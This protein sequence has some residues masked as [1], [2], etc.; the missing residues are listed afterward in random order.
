MAITCNK[1]NNFRENHRTREKSQQQE[2]GVGW[3]TRKEL[4]TLTCLVALAPQFC[5]LFPR[6]FP[7]FSHSTGSEYSAHPSTIWL[8]IFQPFIW[9]VFPASFSF[10]FSVSFVRFPGLVVMHFDVSW[11][12]VSCLYSFIVYKWLISDIALRFLRVPFEFVSDLAPEMG[13]AGVV[14]PK[15]HRCR[16]A[17]QSLAP[18]EQ[19][20]PTR[21]CSDTFGFVVALF[22][23]NWATIVAVLWLQV[24]WLW[25]D[26]RRELLGINN[27]A[28]TRG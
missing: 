27:C 24:D 25:L 17:V 8:A 22:K 7:A 13:W 11:L 12:K 15:S 3:N 9:A 4:F 23:L 19:C 21:Y 2:L 1:G 26:R 6:N 5:R 20:W 14:R 16:R 18:I 10:S 28:I